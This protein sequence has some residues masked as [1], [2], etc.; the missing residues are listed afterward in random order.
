MESKKVSTN[1]VAVF[2]HVVGCHSR[3]YRMGRDYLA[4]LLNLVAGLAQYPLVFVRLNRQ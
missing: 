2:N 4:R 3:G 1:F